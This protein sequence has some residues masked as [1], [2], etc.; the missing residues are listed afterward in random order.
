MRNGD[1]R[2]VRQSS[3]LSLAFRIVPAMQG[4]ISVDG[5][6][7][8]TLFEELFNG[9]DHASRKQTLPT[10]FSGH[11]YRELAPRPIPRRG[12]LAIKS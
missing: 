11:S 2:V 12:N 1:T 4:V 10:E 9:H 7:D 5:D 8:G 6:G 3:V